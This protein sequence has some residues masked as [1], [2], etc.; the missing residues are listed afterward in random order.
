MG[1]IHCNPCQ[2]D[3]KI[4]EISIIS[5]IKNTTNDFNDTQLTLKKNPFCGDLFL[6]N[7]ENSNSNK[8]KFDDQSFILNTK[9]QKVLNKSQS[10]ILL[11]SFIRGALFRLKF[12]KLRVI[13]K[14]EM[15]KLIDE[16][17]INLI[18]EKIKKTINSLSPLNYNKFIELNMTN[19]QN[20]VIL[21]QSKSF[22]K[23]DE[24]YKKTFGPYL[25]LYYDSK[26]I[27]NV[28]NTN[29]LK[30]HKNED[31]SSS[32]TNNIT[33]YS[34]LINNGCKI[35]PNKHNEHPV[36]I[37]QKNKEIY[38]NAKSFYYGY[39]NI[40]NQ[41]HGK[42]IFLSNDNKFYDGYWSNNKFHGCNRIINSKG[43]I[44]EG[45]LFFYRIFYFF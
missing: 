13:M 28:D 15:I 32:T 35:E 37:N 36:F 7:R 22:L 30:S 5:I 8:T 43:I 21:S 26:D 23:N 17:K 33:N 38:S 41:R 45:K 25:I 39:V 16:V 11:Q 40:K 24:N 6:A 1:K 42:G 3:G 10:C 14:I 18:P 12:K 29:I 2:K 20:Q 27:L 4:D 9:K 19:S 31:I 34:N 44:T